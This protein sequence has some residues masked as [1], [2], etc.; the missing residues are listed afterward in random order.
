MIAI[1]DYGM[2][3][4]KSVQNALEYIGAKAQIVSTPR[5]IETCSKVILP[6]VGAFKT[7]MENIKTASN[8]N[9]TATKQLEDS[10]RTLQT[11]SNDYLKMLEQ[12]K[13]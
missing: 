1:V 3:N 10:A 12:F 11:I 2:G 13:V 6:G 5:G 8:Q 9:A 4:L 7:A